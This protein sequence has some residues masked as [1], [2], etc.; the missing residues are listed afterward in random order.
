MLFESYFSVEGRVFGY[1]DQMIDGIQA[2]TDGVELSL[3]RQCE[4]KLHYSVFVRCR[5]DNWT[6]SSLAKL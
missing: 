4:G 6:A 5:D 2:K 1:D 3:R